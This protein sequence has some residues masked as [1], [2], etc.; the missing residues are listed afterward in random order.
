[1]SSVPLA[2]PGRLRPVA[3]RR[4]R[5]VRRRVIVITVLAALLAAGPL[6]WRLRSVSISAFPG[7][8]KAAVRSLRSLQGTPIALISLRKAR[9]L[10]EVWPGVASVD[11]RLKLP[12]RLLVTV[13]PASVNGSF[14]TGRG[15]HAVG[16]D[17]AVGARLARPA[18]PV[19]EGFTPEAI[20]LR[21]GLGIARRLAEETGRTV[22]AVRRIL[23]DDFEVQLA[24]SDSG[25]PGF[26]VHVRSSAG[27]AELWW[28]RQLRSGHAPG[29]RADLRRDDAL[30]VGGRG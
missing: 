16:E 13:H 29:T 24:G 12:G 10:A 9:G 28:T 11:A 6:I 27:R 22:L 25:G 15:W 4:T 2:F 20:A 7:F 18:P 5:R 26:L 17:G 21:E 23:P 14:P 3:V 30:I 8:P 19:L 1:M